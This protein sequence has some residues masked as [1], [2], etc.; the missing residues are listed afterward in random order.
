M[1]FYHEINTE[2]QVMFEHN[3]HMSAA[4]LVSITTPILV[5]STETTDNDEAINSDSICL[6]QSKYCFKYSP[7]FLKCM[8]VF[9]SESS[10]LKM[11]ENFGK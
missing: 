11:I 7:Y 9:Q 6:F 3:I 10:R 5:W 4:A 8:F 2:I 1:Y